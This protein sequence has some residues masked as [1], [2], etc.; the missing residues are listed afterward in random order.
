MNRQRRSRIILV[1]IL[2]LC[3]A[4]VLAAQWL[5]RSGQVQGGQSF[6]E[7]LVQ[8]G[9]LP[10]GERWVLLAY[11]PGGCPGL[12]TVAV[13]QLA[14]AQGREAARL[15]PAAALGCRTAALPSRTPQVPWTA[16][17][18]YLI[19]PHGNAVLRYSVEQLTSDTGRRQALGEIGRVLKN[20]K[21]LG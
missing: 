13:R 20:N 19:D 14:V 15:E 3:I 18:V 8:P 17:G 5:Y 11:A 4:P 7:L 12:L 2:A 9:A 6:G 1:A 21:A 16:A 10:A